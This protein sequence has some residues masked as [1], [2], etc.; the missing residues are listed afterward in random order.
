MTFEAFTDSLIKTYLKEIYDYNLLMASW[1][2]TRSTIGGNLCNA[3][4]IAD[5]TCLLI[6]LE[7]SLA[8]TSPDGHKGVAT[9]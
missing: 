5:M 3:S 2:R 1:P 7:A 8:L 6:A 4:P 9:S